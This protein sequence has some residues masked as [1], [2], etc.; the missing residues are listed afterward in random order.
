MV[1]VYFFYIVNLIYVGVCAHIL[2]AGTAIPID[3]ICES[4]GLDINCS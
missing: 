3:F 2:L 4:N 1:I